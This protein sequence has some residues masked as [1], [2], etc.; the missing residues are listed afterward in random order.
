[1]VCRMQCSRHEANEGSV[2]F[3]CERVWKPTTSLLQKPS[4]TSIPKNSAMVAVH[5]HWGWGL[6]GAFWGSDFFL[7]MRN[8]RVVMALMAA[9]GFS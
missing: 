3:A 4:L 5:R 7:C 9:N 1:V 8:G 6:A 2:R